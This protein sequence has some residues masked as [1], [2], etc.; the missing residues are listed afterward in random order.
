LCALAQFV[1]VA[2]QFLQPSHDALGVVGDSV[3]VHVA[4]EGDETLPGDLP[5][6][7]FGVVVQAGPTVN[8]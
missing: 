1:G 5:S 8:D 2:S 4:G 7:A 6:A 3:S